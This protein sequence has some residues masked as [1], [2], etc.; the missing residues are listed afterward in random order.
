MTESKDRAA[1]RKL[2]WAVDI[3]QQGMGLAAPIY[4]AREALAEPDPLVERA[5]KAERMEALLSEREIAFVRK[6]AALVEAVNILLPY[7]KHDG[8]DAAA[9]KIA[10]VRA[11]IAQAYPVTPLDTKQA[12]MVKALRQCISS[13]RWAAEVLQAPDKS[14]FREDIVEAQAALK[15]AEES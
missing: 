1:L 7:F 9:E 8:S 14:S 12:A 6:Q 13:M 2:L 15:A 11:A 4:M 10:K 5:E 3:P